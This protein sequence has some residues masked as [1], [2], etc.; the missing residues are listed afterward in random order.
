MVRLAEKT[1]G[2]FRVQVL[3]VN[4]VWKNNRASKPESLAGQSI[5][6]GFRGEGE[7]RMMQQAFARTLERGQTFPWNWVMEK[8]TGGMFWNSMG[9]NGSRPGGPWVRGEEISVA[10]GKGSS[11]VSGVLIAKPGRSGEIERDVHRRELEMIE[12]R[13]RESRDAP[14]EAELSRSRERAPGISA[15]TPCDRSC[16]S[17]F[18]AVS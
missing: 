6:V 12:K 18:C 15:S 8:E 14:R 17:S 16:K 3:R 4:R 13:K 5:L 7:A 10:S 11:L 1:D 2:G 9:I